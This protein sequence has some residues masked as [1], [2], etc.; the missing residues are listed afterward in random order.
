MRVRRGSINL[1]NFQSFT[2][3]S[4]KDTFDGGKYGEMGHSAAGSALPT[5]R[6][7]MLFCLENIFVSLKVAKLFP[8]LYE[9]YV[10][11]CIGK[12]LHHLLLVAS[13]TPW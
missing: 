5:A 11:K 6:D 1:Q 13:L 9:S 3:N 7:T 10:A 8:F 4:F 12:S 2:Q